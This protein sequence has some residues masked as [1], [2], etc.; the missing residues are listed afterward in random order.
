M[1]KSTESDSLPKWTAGIA[2]DQYYARV[3]LIRKIKPFYVR[4]LLGFV[5][6]H[7]K[8]GEAEM[9]GTA[10]EFKKETGVEVEDWTSRGDLYIRKWGKTIGVLKLHTTRLSNEQMDCIRANEDIG[11]EVVVAD[12]TANNTVVAPSIPMVNPL[13]PMLCSPLWTSALLD[14]DAN[15][16]FRQIMRRKYNVTDAK[17]RSYRVDFRYRDGDGGSDSVY[18]V[19][20]D[21]A[22]DLVSFRLMPDIVDIVVI[23]EDL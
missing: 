10:R 17:C 13:L 7:L 9:D 2:F 19:S 18:A 1:K 3:V 6:G 23:Q 15:G 20:K 5:G 16:E 4:G 12:L 22:A 21:A 14:Y 8:N 11:E